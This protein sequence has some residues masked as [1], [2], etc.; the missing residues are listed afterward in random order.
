M[1]TKEIREEVYRNE[2]FE[3]LAGLVDGNSILLAISEK[4]A[5]DENYVLNPTERYIL[6]VDYRLGKLTKCIEVMLQIELFL[7]RFPDKKFFVEHG[8]SETDYL[9]YHIK[10]AV[11]QMVSFRDM[12]L[13]LT[14]ELLELGV[15][16]GVTNIK[17]QKR[18]QPKMRKA[19]SSVDEKGRLIKL[20][21]NYDEQLKQM[22][23]FRNLHIHEGEFN[24]GTLREVHRVQYLIGMTERYNEEIEPWMTNRYQ[25]ARWKLKDRRKEL[26]ELTQ[27]QR[28]GME[29]SFIHFTK[30]LAGEFW[31]RVKRKED[32]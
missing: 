3:R 5:T 13:H 30:M 18:N 31:Q 27:N 1:K 2:I 32:E 11:V 26:I 29:L 14:N 7:R 23:Q 17:K 16:R 19:L 22:T 6:R 24:D 28:N 20:F 15:E 25:I 21:D 12:L 9:E 4:R 10:N 8:F